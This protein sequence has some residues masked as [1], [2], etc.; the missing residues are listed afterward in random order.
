MAFALGTPTL[1]NPPTLNNL[2][3]PLIFASLLTGLAEHGAAYSLDEKT[4]RVPPANDLQRFTLVIVPEEHNLSA[5]PF[6]AGGF[7]DVFKE[8]IEAR[9]SLFSFAAL[10]VDLFGIVLHF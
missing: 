3:K 2:Q 5:K 6:R 4:L 10:P 1:V 7:V 8:M 9:R